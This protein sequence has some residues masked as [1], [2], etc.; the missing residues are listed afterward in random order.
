MT[1]LPTSSELAA[2]KWLAARPFYEGM[3]VALA[4]LTFMSTRQIEWY[5]AGELPESFR[6]LSS[7]PH[8]CLEDA[9][10]AA[11]GRP[12]LRVALGYG[13]RDGK[14][15]AHVWAIDAAGEVVDLS[16]GRLGKPDGYLGVG[17]EIGGLWTSSRA[18]ESR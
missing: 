17:E 8:G 7:V 6:G 18:A 5:S 3:R 1:V 14:G 12:D 16:T 2:R 13:F 9:L 4:A 11:E 15:Y 10:R